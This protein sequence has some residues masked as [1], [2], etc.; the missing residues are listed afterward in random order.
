MLFYIFF[1]RDFFRF[2]VTNT[3]SNFTIII[4]SNNYPNSQYL[5]TKP[6]KPM[7]HRPST[8]FHPQKFQ[9]CRAAIFFTQKSNFY[10]L[11]AKMGRSNKL[12]L[13]W[14]KILRENTCKLGLLSNRQ[15]TG[16]FK[17]VRVREKRIHAAS[18]WPF[19]PENFGN[20][21][22]DHK[23]SDHVQENIATLGIVLSDQPSMGNSCEK[24][25]G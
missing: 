16:L 2:A 17:L 5:I 6:T 21:S 12:T 19:E 8:Q 14:L 22:S 13:F 4:N 7:G 1:L 3:N 11:M 10:R 23:R 25:E 20:V 24:P 15:V 9:R 18:F